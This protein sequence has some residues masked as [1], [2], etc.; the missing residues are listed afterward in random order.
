MKK[1]YSKHDKNDIVSGFAVNTSLENS[2]EA[3]AFEQKSLTIG[4]IEW[5][6]VLVAAIITVVIIFTL[7]FRVATIDGDSMK[8]T[9]FENEKIIISNLNYTPKQR[10]IVVISRNIENSVDS[11]TSYNTPIIKRVIA[12]GGQTVNID[13]NTGTVYVD[14]KALDEPYISSKTNKHDVE[15]PLYVPEGYI[16]VLGDNRAESLD[17]RSSS[18]GEGG[19]IDT[20]YVLGHAVYRIF[21]FE[22]IGRLDNK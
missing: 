11:Q 15:F 1:Y 18:I 13:F 5:L 2:E 12:V 9:L 16:F 17:S 8:N 20:R 14:G 19:L 4:L 22:K 7:V 21:P 10:D 6:E 3:P